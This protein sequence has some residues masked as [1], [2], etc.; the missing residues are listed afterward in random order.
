[1]GMIGQRVTRL[2]DQAVRPVIH[3]V[4]CIVMNILP[5]ENLG[6]GKLNG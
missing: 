3:Q 2:V 5:T 6:G 4:G 1:M